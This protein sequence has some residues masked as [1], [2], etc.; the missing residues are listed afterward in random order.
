[1]VFKLTIHSTGNGSCALTGRESDGLTVTFEDGTIQEV[2]LSWRAFRQLL[3][4]K[5]GQGKQTSVKK[6][7]PP[8]AD[9]VK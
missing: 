4:L 1:M 9:K 8:T 3:S 2:F 7:P 5:N 6:E